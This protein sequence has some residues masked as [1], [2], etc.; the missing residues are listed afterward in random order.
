MRSGWLGGAAAVAAASPGDA[1]RRWHAECGEQG[2]LEFR[3]AHRLDQTRGHPLLPEPGS[4][5]LLF[6]AAQHHDDG[7]GLRAGLPHRPHQA[8]TAQPRHLGIRQHQFERPAGPLRPAEFQ[9][10]RH[11]VGRRP[12]LHAPTGKGLR[13][14]A[15]GGR[16]VIHHQH[17]NPPESLHFH[18]PAAGRRGHF[19]CDGEM[20]AAAFPRFAL[21]PDPA[22]HH[23]HQLGGDRQAQTGAAILARH[24]R[25][26]LCEGV[27]DQLPLLDGDADPG[28]GDDEVQGRLSGGTLLR[29]DTH[30]NLAFFGE[31]QG[32]AEQVYDHLAETGWIGGGSFR[33]V[34]TDLAGELDAFLRRPQR[35]RPNGFFHQ[36]GQI[37]FDGVHFQLARFD[38]GE[39]QNVV[40]D[41]QQRVRGGFGGLEKLA[42]FAGQAGIQRQVDHSRHAVHGSANLVAHIRQ[43][44]ALGPVGGLGRFLQRVRLLQLRADDL[45]LGTDDFA[46]ALDPASQDNHPAK[47][48]QR[49]R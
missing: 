15:A 6:G 48:T 20:E 24:G 23:L 16:V 5:V 2:R 30:G 25:V 42:L 31:L 37:E 28:V 1:S 7:A 36:P 12:R 13:Q 17:G 34:G 45:Q 40:D 18:V 4:T 21:D 41:R 44:L 10:R 49:D 35:K 26:F 43:E 33:N 27:E 9:E 32:V 22:A 14:D 8:G 47:H 29:E 11:A 3:P 19:D 38:L 39:I 46:L